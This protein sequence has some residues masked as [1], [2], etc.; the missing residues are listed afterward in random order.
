MAKNGNEFLDIILETGAENGMAPEMYQ[1]YTLLKDNKI[2]IN[3]AVDRSFV[4][5]VA[6][7][8]LQMENDPEVQEIEII[9]N[10]EG[11]SVFDG[12]YI[13]DI[14]D[15]LHTPTTITVLGY[16]YSMA[17][18]FLMAGYNNPNVTKRCY[19]FSSFLLHAGQSGVSGDTKAVKDTMKFYD[20]QEKKLE[21]YVLTHSKITKKEY[22][23]MY[24]SETYL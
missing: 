2:L 4:E 9:I 19:P 5:W 11:G 14:I 24:S 6:M 3:S 13:C 10:C 8:L 17:G 21:D 7:P 16:A 20:M 18:Y 22:K 12:T 1:Y 15:N 23:K